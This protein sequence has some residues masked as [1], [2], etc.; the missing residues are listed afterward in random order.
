MP[1]ASPDILA[2]F[3]NKACE[4]EI[5]IKVKVNIDRERFRADLYAIRKAMAKP[6]W[7]E[8]ILF[9]P[10]DGCV[11]FVRKDTEMPE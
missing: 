4:A 9:L 1:V 3:W 11:W 8:F 6:E 5:G 7:D 10:N 2:A